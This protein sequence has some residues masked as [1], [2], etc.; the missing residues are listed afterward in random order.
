MVAREPEEITTMPMMITAWF[1]GLV[2]I[3]KAIFMPRATV[4]VGD[5]RGELEEGGG[6][7]TR[8]KGK[9]PG[10]VLIAEVTVTA[11]PWF[12][13]RAQKPTGEEVSISLLT[14]ALLLY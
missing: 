14:T 12:M 8:A 5:K 9:N 6:E 10:T 13:V 4:K 11:P 1:K 7:L 3:F 2:L